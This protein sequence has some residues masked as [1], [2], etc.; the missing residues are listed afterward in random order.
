MVFELC[1]GLC[2]LCVQTLRAVATEFHEDAG[3]TGFAA[4]TV[5]LSVKR[6]EASTD[7]ALVVNEFYHSSL[8]S[9][10]DRASC[11]EP[12]IGF[13]GAAMPHRLDQPSR[14]NCLFDRDG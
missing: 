14:L 4:D 13:Y 12:F 5:A 3:S 11:F 10:R 7:G 6:F 1:E 9:V 8:S 2:S